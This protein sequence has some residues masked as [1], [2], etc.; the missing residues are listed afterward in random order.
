MQLY[1]SAGP[2][3]LMTI[4]TG[5]DALWKWFCRPLILY[6]IKTYIIS[7]FLTRLASFFMGLHA[8]GSFAA[9][10]S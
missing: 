10:V 6:W 4:I 3:F 7:S 9:S 1:V 5:L 2:D 8:E